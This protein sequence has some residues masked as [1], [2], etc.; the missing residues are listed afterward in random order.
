ML[1]IGCPQIPISHRLR[2]DVPPVYADRT[3]QVLTIDRTET[4]PALHPHC[5]SV[6]DLRGRLFVAHVLSRME[7][8]FV[9]DLIAQEIQY[10]LPLAQRESYSGRKRYFIDVPVFPQYV[11]VAAGDDTDDAVGET[12]A[13]VK[14]LRPVRVCRNIHVRNQGR[15]RHDLG[16]LFAALSVNRRIE[17]CP[18]VKGQRVRICEG[19]FQNLEGVILERPDSAILVLSVGEVGYASMEI[20]RVMVEPV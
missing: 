1:R 3:I 10:Y 5:A 18:L 13:R 11:F 14:G 16:N 6:D 9:H 2:N 20:P 8:T 19:A 17:Q 4:P 7:K 12:M 15:L